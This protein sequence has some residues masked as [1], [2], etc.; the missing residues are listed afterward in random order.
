MCIY[1]NQCKFI[2]WCLKFKFTDK[3]FKLL[4]CSPVL[5]Q[6]VWSLRVQLVRV[7]D[8]TVLYTSGLKQLKSVSCARIG[9]TYNSTNDAYKS[10]TYVKTDGYVSDTSLI[11]CLVCNR[12]YLPHFFLLGALFPYNKKLSFRGW[13]FKCS[14]I[15]K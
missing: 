13:T 3:T 5:M 15:V 1:F 4:Q 14:A 11:A 9:Y 10:Y 6:F 8:F 7:G 12:D 2:G